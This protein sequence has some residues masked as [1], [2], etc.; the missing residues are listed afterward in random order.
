MPCQGAVAWLGGMGG[1]GRAGWAGAG[2]GVGRGGSARR[3]AAGASPNRGRASLARSTRSGV[4]AAAARGRRSLASAQRPATL[5]AP[6]AVVSTLLSL[7]DGVIDRGEV[8][9]VGATNR[10][11]A[12][13]PA[14][15]RPGRF[16]REVGGQVAE[17]PREAAGFGSA[18]GSW[19]T[20]GADQEA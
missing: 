4:H 5:P 16:D 1:V 7:M 8:V 13:D 15:R 9:V 14:L 6:R 12:V 17:W 18:G 3:P 19:P 2:A 10:P 20:R 11:E